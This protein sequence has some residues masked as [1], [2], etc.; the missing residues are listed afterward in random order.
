MDKGNVRDRY[1]EREKI[2][3][4]YEKK[5]NP[6]ICN[7]TNEPWGQVTQSKTMTAWSPVYV[8][9]K[10]IKFTETE[11]RMVVVIG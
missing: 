7:N 4:I 11:K 3:C 6:A 5:E 2:E 9:S 10:N 8:E 1:K